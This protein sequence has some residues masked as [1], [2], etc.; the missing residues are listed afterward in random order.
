MFLASG[1]AGWAA[2]CRLV[3]ATHLAGERG[4]PVT[5]PELIAEHL[6]DDVLV[7]LGP[8]STLGD[9]A[10]ARRD[11]HARAVLDR[12]REIVPPGNLV[13]EVT[14]HR[15]PGHGPGSSP[16]AARMVGVA[17]SA[18][19][20]VVLSNAVRY[21][22]RLDAPTIDVLD[23]ARTLVPLGS[24]G[25]SRVGPG[26]FRGNAEGF[27]KS[28]KQM[29]DVAEEICRHA[30]LGND[31]AHAGQELLAQTRKIAD[32]CVIDPKA[33][34][35]LGEIHFPEF[36]FARGTSSL[37]PRDHERRLRSVGPNRRGSG[38]T[39]DASRNQAADAALRQ[40]CEG[41]IGWR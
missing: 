26:G 9:A 23:A 27:L 16:H 5:T 29:H 17:R 10:T 33:D 3:S 24:A 37:A 12:W 39:D 2:I 11:D 7:L 15:L 4:R 25:L 14:S 18:G 36:E 31:T 34:L 22:D 32:R 28:G 13:V 1:K 20:P 38:G 8:T 6:G 21:A 40:R 35:G 19:L 41:A 30:G